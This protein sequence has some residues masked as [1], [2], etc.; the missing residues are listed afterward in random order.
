VNVN[1]IE[2][3]IVN[4]L[5]VYVETEGNLCSVGRIGL[6]LA[7]WFLPFSFFFNLYLS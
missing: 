7:C 5:C 3:R 1:F 6:N 2:V 4:S